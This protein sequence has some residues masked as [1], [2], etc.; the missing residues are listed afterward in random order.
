MLTT[1]KA[2]L[3]GALSPRVLKAGFIALI[4]CVSGC[5]A[6]CVLQQKYERKR[7]MTFSHS[8]I[9]LVRTSSF[10][11]NFSQN[12]NRFRV[13]SSFLLSTA[14]SINVVGL[15]ECSQKGA[16]NQT[17]FIQRSLVYVEKVVRKL[18]SS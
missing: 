10:V 17:F 8:L 9:L 12:I 13:T 7:K 11:V 14:M 1:L 4:S 15:R 18:I 2:S 6:Y 16:S 3:F 5:P